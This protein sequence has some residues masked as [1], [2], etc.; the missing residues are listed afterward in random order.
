MKDG[1]AEHLT[2][3]ERMRGNRGREG[4]GGIPATLS[5]KGLTMGS[6]SCAMFKIKKGVTYSS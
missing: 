5:E 1:C 3:L 4:E 6:G 2:E